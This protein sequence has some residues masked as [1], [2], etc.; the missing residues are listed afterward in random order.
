MGP[1]ELK[2]I[3]EML[4][5][6]IQYIYPGYITIY[7]YYFLRGKTLHDNKQTFLKSIMLSYIYKT[8]TA[9]I[10]VDSVIW[11]NIGYIVLSV[12]VAYGGYWITTSQWIYSVFDFFNIKTTY[13]ENEVEALAGCDNS[14]WLI[15]Y[16]KSS[17][18]AIEGSLGYKELEEGKDRYIT[19]DAY[20]KY[21]VN[22]DGTLSKPPICCYEGQYDEQCVIK[23]DDIKMI[24]KRPTVQVK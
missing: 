18:I 22:D 21:S 3:I 11:A 1:G 19:L 2:E 13:F 15:V 5:E 6:Y 4:P 8:L 24:E 14:A 23:Y 7:T 9:F 10:P 20:T 12:V 16:T 17:N